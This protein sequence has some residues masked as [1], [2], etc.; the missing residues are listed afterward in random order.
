MII[1]QLILFERA[2]I[3]FIIIIRKIEIIKIIK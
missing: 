3:I 2:N 1:F